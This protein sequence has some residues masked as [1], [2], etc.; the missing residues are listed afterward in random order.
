MTGA[1]RP[2]STRTAALAARPADGS[3]SIIRPG[4]RPSDPYSRAPRRRRTSDPETSGHPLCRLTAQ[5]RCGDMGTIRRRAAR[6]LIRAGQR[7]NGGRWFV[8]TPEQSV[9][10]QHAPGA[11]ETPQPRRFESTDALSRMCERLSAIGPVTCAL[12]DGTFVPIEETL[13]DLQKRTTSELH[14]LR[15][16]VAICGARSLAVV[17]LANGKVGDQTECYTRIVFQEDAL[18]AVAD[19]PRIVWESTVKLSTW[20]RWRHEPVIGRISAKEVA[21]QAEGRRLARI[22]GA[23]G[24]LSGAISGIGATMLSMWLGRS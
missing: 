7:V 21:A 6:T 1:A 24:F 18:A 14:S 22:A 23:W 5:V 16:M 15:I 3:C 12:S 4:T 10:R 19:I 9:Y 17:H 20:Q 2:P 8:T 11:Y 13:A